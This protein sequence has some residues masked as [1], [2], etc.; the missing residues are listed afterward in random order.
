MKDIDSA[1]ETNQSCFIY[2]V[3][4]IIIKDNYNPGIF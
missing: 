1:F 2:R 4:A 3:A